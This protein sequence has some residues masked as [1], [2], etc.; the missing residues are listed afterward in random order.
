MVVLVMME[1]KQVCTPFA[2][3]SDILFLHGEG[4]DSGTRDVA[5][6]RAAV[7]IRGPACVKVRRH[8]NGTAIARGVSHGPRY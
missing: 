7:G 6:E 5:V 3:G 4:R 2:A 1:P 8:P